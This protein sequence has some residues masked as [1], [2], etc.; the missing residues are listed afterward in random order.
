MVIVIEKVP[1][2]FQALISK[3]TEFKYKTL[4]NKFEISNRVYEKQVGGKEDISDEEFIYIIHRLDTLETRLT[5]WKEQ[6]K[7]LAL[8]Y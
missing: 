1:L 7:N 4:D 3:E 6:L 2:K 8:I 5:V